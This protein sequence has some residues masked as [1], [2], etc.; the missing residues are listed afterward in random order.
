MEEVNLVKII[1]VV[2]SPRTDGNTFYLVKNALKSAEAIGAD[3]EI[4][5]LGSKEIEPCIACDICKA[6]GECGIYDDMREIEEKLME[7]DG[8]IIGSPVY[9]GNV[10]SQLKMFI[11]RT[12]PLRGNF[13]LKDKV[14]GAI[15]VGGSRN[16]GQE[17]TIS[18]I[19][20]FLLIHDTIVVGDGAPLAHYGGTGVGGPKGDTIKDE[21]GIETS[22]NI[23][24]RVA[25][26]ASRLK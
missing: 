1:G 18:A 14:C 19:H 7:S 5:N 17:S 2:G 3:T 11:D 25:E 13:K 6:T 26:L 8:I 12:R 10:T 23:G 20:D 4:I 22:K 24:K 9:F 16:G 15:A 21:I